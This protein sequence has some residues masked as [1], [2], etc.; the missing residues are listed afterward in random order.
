VNVDGVEVFVTVSCGCSN[1]VVAVLVLLPAAGSVVPTGGCAVALLMIEVP[2]VGAVAFTVNVTVAPLASVVIVLVTEVAL[3]LT[4]PQ[5][6]VPV[7]TAQLAVTL[8]RPAGNVSVNVVPFAALGPL[9][10]T[11]IE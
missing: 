6:A 8:V 10:C 5:V 7:V 3:A 4:V 1:V 11:V 2:L 9:L